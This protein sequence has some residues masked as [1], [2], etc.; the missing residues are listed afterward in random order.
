MLQWGQ[1]R[2][3][4]KTQIQ[5]AEESNMNIQFS[6]RRIAGQIR[7]KQL[8][9]AGK[10]L[11]ALGWTLL[12]ILLMAQSVSAAGAGGGGGGIIQLMM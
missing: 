6:P 5:A 7:S 3:Q 12:L 10:L 4:C 1:L 9:V 2:S 11:L 8:K